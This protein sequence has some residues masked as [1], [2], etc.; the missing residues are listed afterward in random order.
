MSQ[1][2]A[3]LDDLDYQDYLRLKRFVCG[4]PRPAMGRTWRRPLP[5]RCET[6]VE[7]WIMAG[8]VFVVGSFF[9]IVACIVLS[10]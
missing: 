6:P 9:T 5:W 2:V 10:F 4:R 1:Q 7:W 3:T 8:Y